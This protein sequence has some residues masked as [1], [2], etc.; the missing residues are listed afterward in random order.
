MSDN[1]FDYFNSLK[2]TGEILEDRTM[3][4]SKEADEL[5]STCVFTLRKKQATAIGNAFINLDMEKKGEYIKD[6]GGLL[7]FKEC[8]SGHF[9]KLAYANFCGQRLCPMCQW[10]RSL[11]TFGQVSQIYRVLT[12]RFNERSYS[13]LM[14]TLTIKNCEHGE[15]KNIIENLTKGFNRLFDCS[16]N[17]LPFKVQVILEPLR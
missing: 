9:K 11:K 3:L 10:R 7:G 5:E 6:C 16:K 13:A 2:D 12:T 15:L 4:V 8:P 17:R 1:R 14:L